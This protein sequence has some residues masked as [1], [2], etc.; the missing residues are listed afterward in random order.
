MN[1]KAN[2]EKKRSRNLQ[3]G[4]GIGVCS[5]HM[6]RNTQRN[7]YDY[8]AGDLTFRNNVQFTNRI[9]L[10]DQQL[11]GKR[12][13]IILRYTYKTKYVNGGC[14]GGTGECVFFSFGIATSNIDSELE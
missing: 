8:F 12:K 13:K 14:D 10:T 1:R 5:A 6:Q 7:H 2:I 11:N 4:N 9:V 3:S